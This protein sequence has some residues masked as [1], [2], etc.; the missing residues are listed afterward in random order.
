MRVQ[1]GKQKAPE[2]K[3]VNRKRN[4]PAGAPVVKGGY[5]HA[6]QKGSKLLFQLNQPIERPYY[7]R[8]IAS[9]KGSRKTPRQAINER[10]HTTESER[11][12]R[13]YSQVKGDGRY[14]AGQ[15]DKRAD[16][17]IAKI[18]VVDVSSRKPGIKRRHVGTAQDGIEKGQLHRLLAAIVDVPEIRIEHTHP[19]HRQ[20]SQR[21]NALLDKQQQ[22]M[23]TQKQSYGSP[24]P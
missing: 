10:K 24:L 1:V 17:N 5:W 11:K 23:F 14:N 13:R 16:E 12:Q 21:K 2:R 4:H 6:C 20:Q 7:I 3:L 22:P 19:Y 18:V 9:Q 15:L 8:E